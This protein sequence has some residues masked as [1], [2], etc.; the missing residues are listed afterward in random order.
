MKEFNLELAKA[1]HPVQ[2]RD[3]RPA[4]IICFDRI[5]EYYPI[6]ALIKNDEHKEEQCNSYTKD[7]KC[8][9]YSSNN[10]DD[11]IMVS[12]KKEG[13]VNIYHSSIYVA[14][15]SNAYETKEDALKGKSEEGYI[16]TI[17]IEWEE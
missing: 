8:Y 4:R 14:G 3:G 5:D 13:W 16:N 1:G 17:K 2:T 9:A 15:V 12:T 10:P 11:L 7:G 6:I